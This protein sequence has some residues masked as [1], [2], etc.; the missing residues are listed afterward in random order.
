MRSLL[1]A[2]LLTDASLLALL[3][4][5]PAPPAGGAADRP[6]ALAEPDTEYRLPPNELVPDQVQAS[7]DAGD[8][9]D[10]GH[11]TI[12]VPDAWKVTKGKGATV[13][14]L[15]TGCDQSHRDLKAQLVAAKDFTGSRSGSSDVNGHG[16]HCA[17]IVL[18]AE[19]GVGMVGVAPEARLLVGKVLSDSG[20]GLSTWIAAGIDWSVENGADVISMSLGSG[21]PDQRIGA[22]VQRALDKGVLVIAAAG[23]EGPREG[24]AGWPGSFPGVICVAAVDNTQA[25]ARFSSRG[26]SVVVAA[27]GVNVRSC[28]PGDRFANMSGT[29]MATPYVAGCAAL[30]V[31]QAKAKGVKY[32]PA[33]FAKAVEATSKDLPPQGRDTASGFGLVQPAKLLPS[34][35]TDPVIP[36]IPPISGDRLEISIP[37]EYQ[38]RKLLKIV[39]E[40]A[41]P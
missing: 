8:A 41:K 11:Q 35:G 15:D 6:R 21:S 24:T 34:G 23:N 20:S 17:G 16:T 31:S 38:G 4:N 10:W 28:Y 1:I 7:Q 33:E 39:L 29:S 3:V 2:A 5:A 27:P 9:P 13:A 22:A 12:G 40:F 37:P 36:P 19:N 25:V 26:K 18:A 30:Y 32:T 14:V